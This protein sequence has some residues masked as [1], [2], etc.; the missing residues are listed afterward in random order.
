MN[1]EKQI[2]VVLIIHTQKKKKNSHTQQTLVYST[3]MGRTHVHC[4]KAKPKVASHSAN[5]I[6]WDPSGPEYDEIE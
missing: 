6:S 1:K 2:E 3:V 4:T 5:P